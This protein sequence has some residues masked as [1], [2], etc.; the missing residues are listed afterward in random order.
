MID[1]NNKMPLM[2]LICFI[3]IKQVMKLNPHYSIIYTVGV[4]DNISTFIFLF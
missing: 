3:Y 1:G 4:N 2:L